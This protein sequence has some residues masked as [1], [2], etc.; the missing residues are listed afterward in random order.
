[1]RRACANG[2]AVTCPPLPTADQAGANAQVR[3]QDGGHERI[4]FAAWY[5]QMGGYV[6]LAVVVDAK[7]NPPGCFEAWVWHDGEFPFDE[8]G[9]QHPAHLH[10]CDPEQFVEFGETVRAKLNPAP[11]TGT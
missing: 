6:A 9:G 4:G 10:H 11:G 2:E 5:P 3:W 1:M 7:S 8:S